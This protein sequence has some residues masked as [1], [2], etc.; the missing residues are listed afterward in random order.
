[1]ANTHL[2]SQMDAAHIRLLQMGFSMLF[3]QN[4]YS[5]LKTQLKLSDDNLSLIF[6]GDLNSLPERDIF[7]FM[8]N[9]IIA[10]DTEDFKSSK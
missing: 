1:M 3:I 9:K 2:Y 5:N 7:K 8:T 6:C 4:I 10:G